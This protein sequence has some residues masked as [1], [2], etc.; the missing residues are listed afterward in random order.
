M[1]RPIGTVRDLIQDRIDHVLTLVLCLR[2]N[3]TH[4]RAAIT[5]DLF[6]NTLDSTCVAGDLGLKVT[7]SVVRNTDIRK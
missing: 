4:L 6:R 2:K 5:C 1:H 7:Y 3:A